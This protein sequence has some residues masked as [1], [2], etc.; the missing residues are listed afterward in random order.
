M[1]LSYTTGLS[2]KVQAEQGLSLAKSIEKS[3]GRN[4]SPTLN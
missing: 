4:P 3:F 1:P 2:A